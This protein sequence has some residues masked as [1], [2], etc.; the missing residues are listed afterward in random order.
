MDEIKIETKEDQK[1]LPEEKKVYTKP[2]LDVYG[3]LT[4]LTASGTS[5]VAESGSSS[6][7]KKS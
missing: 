7:Q 3:K 1:S 4:E 6:P 5:G 2:T